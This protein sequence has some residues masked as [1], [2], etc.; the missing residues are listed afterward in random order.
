MLPEF[1]HVITTLCFLYLKINLVDLKS[2]AHIFLSILNMLLHFGE[3]WLSEL[4]DNLIF[5]FPEVICPQESFSFPKVQEFRQTASQCCPSES[6]FSGT[7][8]ALSIC[9]FSKVLLN[10]CLVSVPFPLV[11]LFRGFWFLYVGSY[12]PVFN[13][14]HFLK[15]SLSL[16]S[17]PVSVFEACSSHL[18]GVLS[19][20]VCISEF[21]FFNFP[22]CHHLFVEFS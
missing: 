18:L 9:N 6:S 17:F 10:Y 1:L 22:K 15:S 16:F 13:I 2:L 11:F 21:F 7:W 12:L 20:L 14:F 3:E 5:F 4:D 19:R 8:C